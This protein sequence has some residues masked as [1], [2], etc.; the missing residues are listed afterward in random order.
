MVHSFL[1][2]GI[3]RPCNKTLVTSDRG[4]PL[5]Y[6]SDRSFPLLYANDRGF[7]LLYASDRGFPCST[8]VIGVSPALH[9]NS[10]T[11][12]LLN[13]NMKHT[14]SQKNTCL[15]LYS[16]RVR[17]GKEGEEGEEEGKGRR[18]GRP[19]IALS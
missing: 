1:N 12:S 7:P 9:S 3:R 19:P 18:R 15:L 4:F 5:L 17:L 16:S 13:S 11:H 2:K 14:T 6:A 8:Q 10:A